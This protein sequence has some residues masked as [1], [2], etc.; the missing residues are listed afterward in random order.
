MYRL[1]CLPSPDK[2]TFEKVRKLITEFIW[3]ENTYQVAYSK[4]VGDYSDGGLKLVDFQ[5]KDES[6]KI[7][8]IP[9]L[10]NTSAL[11]RSFAYNKLPLRNDMWWECKINP[12]TSIRL[13]GKIPIF[14]KMSQG[15]GLDTITF[16]IPQLSLQKEPRYG[17]TLN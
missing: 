5:L 12:Q 1:Q 9:R 4:L 3:E 2:Q 15:C 11:W 6:L 14:G 10:N 16:D 13:W 7:A 8:W 17:L